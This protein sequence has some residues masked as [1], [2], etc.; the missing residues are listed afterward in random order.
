MINKLYDVLNHQ[1]AWCYDEITMKCFC[2]DK[3]TIYCPQPTSCIYYICLNRIRGVM[4][5]VLATSV[6]DRGIEPRS[7]Q[8]KNYKIGIC[9][10]SAKHAALR[11][12]EKKL[13]VSESEQCVRVE[14]HV[15]PWT[16]F[17]VS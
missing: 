12:K 10:F 14:R 11:K 3:N 17:S 15:H 2:Y 1:H 13:V 5:S 7:G 16:V 4:A 9:C 6:V 8:I